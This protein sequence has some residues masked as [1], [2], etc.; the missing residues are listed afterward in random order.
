MARRAQS[1]GIMLVEWP[2]TKLLRAW[3]RDHG[4][5]AP[6]FGFENAFVAKMLETDEAFTQAL[7]EAGVG[8]R[9][10]QIE[11]VLSVEDLKLLDDLYDARSPSGRPSDWGILVEE[12]R[13]I[14][15][16]VE[17][18]IKVKIE[19]TDTVLTTWQGFYDWAH[20]RYHMLEDGYDK[21]IGDDR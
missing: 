5:P 3:A 12:L 10:P 2:D 1:Q 13:E 6:R 4:W 15:R 20:G 8:L 14:R 21:W 11:Y 7:S 16:A 18:G 17:A 9:I 19:G